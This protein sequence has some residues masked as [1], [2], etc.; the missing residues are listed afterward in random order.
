M[1]T[2]GNSGEVAKRSNAADCK[3]VGPAPSKVRILP[4]PSAF[5]SVAARDASFG[6]E[7]ASLASQPVSRRWQTLPAMAGGWPCTVAR[8]AAG[9]GCRAS[10]TTLC[11]AGRSE[12]SGLARRS[13][14]SGEAG[15][16]EG[17]SNS[18]VESQPSKL[19]VAGSIPVSRSSLFRGGCAPRTPPTASL[20]GAPGP[21]HP[22]RRCAPPAALE[23]GSRR[24]RRRGARGGS[25]RSGMAA[26]SKVERDGRSGLARCDAVLLDEQADLSA[27]AA[28][29]ASG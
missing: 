17:G 20:G 4:S 3:S 15:E 5:R 22:L 7:R 2:H 19:L 28:S 10:W 1:L 25:R 18:M 16:R 9:F 21:R 26:E 8:I 24:S 12:L 13:A 29:E 27:V 11:G 14:E 6:G 23:G